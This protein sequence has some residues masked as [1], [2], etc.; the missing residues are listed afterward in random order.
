MFAGDVRFAV[1]AARSQADAQQERQ[2]GGFS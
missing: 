1:F 2:M